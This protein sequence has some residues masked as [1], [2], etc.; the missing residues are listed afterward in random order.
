MRLQVKKPKPK[1]K[2]LSRRMITKFLW[3]PLLLENEWRWLETASIG[4]TYFNS[5]E[6]VSEAWGN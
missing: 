4:Q 2:S 5:S 3:L 6:W 1:P